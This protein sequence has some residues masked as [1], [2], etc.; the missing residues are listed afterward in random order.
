MLLT[1]VVN[2]SLSAMFASNVTK[3]T[4]LFE[5]LFHVADRILELHLRENITLIAAP[6]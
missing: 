2:S 4:P 3:F 6:P 5:I 1:V